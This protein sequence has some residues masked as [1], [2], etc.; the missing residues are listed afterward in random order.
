[1]QTSRMRHRVQVPYSITRPSRTLGSNR[2]GSQYNSP[3][4][5]TLVE[6]ASDRRSGVT[7]AL[8]PNQ[9]P[10]PPAFAYHTP[11]L[12]A[13]NGIRTLYLSAIL[14][15]GATIP[16]VTHDVHTLCPPV[17]HAQHIGRPAAGG[18]PQGQSLLRSAT[19]N[20]GGVEAAFTRSQ[21]AHIV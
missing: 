3:L 15:T 12:H 6:E 4:D 17:E 8:G 13:H 20:G 16:E 18:W 5:Y 10:S 9:A 19:S 1:M 14:A 2:V 7:D 11:S 21:I